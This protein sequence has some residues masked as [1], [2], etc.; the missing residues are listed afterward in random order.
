MPG[1]TACP[2]LPCCLCPGLTALHATPISVADKC[3][4]V[5]TLG[6]DENANPGASKS[7]M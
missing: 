5:L 3:I 1:L 4:A 2:V 6:V 7:V